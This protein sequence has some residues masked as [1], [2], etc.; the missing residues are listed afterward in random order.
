MSELMALQHICGLLDRG[1][2]DSAQFLELFTRRM[3]Q[4]IGCSRA[5]VRMLIE[6]DHGAALQTMAL[7]DCATNVNVR[8]PDMGSDN[9]APYF[10]ALL[11]DGCIIAPDCKTHPA[12]KPFLSSYFGPQNVFSLLDVSFSV[13]GALYGCFSCEQ[14][15]ATHEWSP[16]Q[17]KLLRRMASRVSLALMHTITTNVDTQPGALCACRLSSC[18]RM[19]SQY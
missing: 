13:N 16:Y 15:S 11:R 1:E 14:I 3:A 18:H 19:A 12:T 6:T 8:V 10:D 17:V 7:H 2:I 4:D 9:P 5:G